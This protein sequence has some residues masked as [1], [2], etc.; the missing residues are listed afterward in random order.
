M[1]E[2]VPVGIGPVRRSQTFLPHRVDIYKSF[3]PDMAAKGQLL[4]RDADRFGDAATVVFWDL[5][6]NSMVDIYGCI[7]RDLDLGLFG[8]N[9]VCIVGCG[10]EACI[11]DIVDFPH[12]APGNR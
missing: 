12:F 4:G 9:E 3:A 6:R 5:M 7:F 2:R 8:G 10:L 11:L 1:V